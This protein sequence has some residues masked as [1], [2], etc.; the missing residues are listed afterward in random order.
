M[1]LKRIVGERRETRFERG[2]VRNVV[3][4]KYTTKTYYSGTV[5]TIETVAVLECGHTVSMSKA[6][7]KKKMQC[8]HA[9]CCEPV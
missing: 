9:E 2:Q 3:T 6:S 7:G 8:F 1:G 4:K 5:E